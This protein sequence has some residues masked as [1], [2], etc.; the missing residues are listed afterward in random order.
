MV[1]PTPVGMDL[2]LSFTTQRAGS[3]LD[4]PGTGGEN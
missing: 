1:P 3:L 2:G 4:F